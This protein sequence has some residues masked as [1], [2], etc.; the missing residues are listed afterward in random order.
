M[1]ITTK[2]RRLP[3]NESSTFPP[4]PIGGFR[5]VN[6]EALIKAQWL[7]DHAA[8]ANRSTLSAEGGQPPLTHDAGESATRSEFSDHRS[9]E[10]IP[11]KFLGSSPWQPR[12]EFDE[13]Q[14]KAL[15][16][17]IAANGGNWSDLLVWH[18]SAEYV[19][20][21]AANGEGRAS[22]SKLP[23][24]FVLAGERRLR[25]ARMTKHPACESLWCRVF[26]GT[27]QE[28]EQLARL[29]NLHRADLNPLEAIRNLKALADSG[30]WKTQ[31][32][33]AREVG[34][35][36]AALS[37]QLRV[38]E[39]PAEILDLISQEIIGPTH[40][41]ALIP[42]KDQ[43][44]TIKAFRDDVRDEAQ[45][46]PQS[47][48]YR[49][50]VREIER[51]IQSAVKCT[52]RPLH[53]DEWIRTPNAQHDR[54]VS[55]QDAPTDAVLKKHEEKLAPVDV[56]GLG[57]RTFNV[58]LWDTLQGQRAAERK[59]PATSKTDKG[60]STPT[61]ADL[62]RRRKQQTEQLQRR[63]YRYRLAWLQGRISQIITQASLWQCL[64][65]LLA[66]CS[67]GSLDHSAKADRARELG[68]CIIAAGGA[69]KCCRFEYCTSIDVWKS[70][71][72][73]PSP[74][75]QGSSD[76]KILNVA[77]DALSRWCRH[78]F[79]GWH[80]KLKPDFLEAAATDLGIDMA[81]EWRCDE[82]F[83]ELHSRE[84]IAELW[85]DWKLDGSLPEAAT[86]AGAIKL[87]L[88]KVSGKQMHFPKCLA[89]L[90]PVRLQ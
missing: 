61:K 35:T 76:G 1:T 29:E 22:G 48:P 18:V 34:L 10:L 40:L 21:A 43:P 63:L 75:G 3:A 85:R 17:S 68:E 67:G 65:H 7:R 82:A 58:Q 41:R 50:T 56:P 25:A 11:I 42:W 13:Q 12:K 49:P 36:P 78:S 54:Y 57:R 84:Q 88:I 87:L 9:R 44:A 46:A 6:R 77:R 90:K 45:R 69:E 20:H 26:D 4:A 72:T 5:D 83:L 19:V 32:E 71:A 89:K 16:E 23:D 53:G 86:K 37:N 47:D 62:E 28:A 30:Q 74:K 80:P 2:R 64:Y 38:L 70:L 31:A 8:D 51:T 81:K 39:L 27:V 59:K 73:L 33:L 66:W 15:G 60:K 24:Y 55:R 14:L 79:E 52:S